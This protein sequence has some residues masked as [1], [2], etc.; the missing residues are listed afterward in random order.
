MGWTF[1]S[2]LRPRG[3]T[4][5][6]GLGRFG[7]GHGHGPVV[8][9]AVAVASIAA[10][11]CVDAGTKHAVPEPVFYAK[12]VKGYAETAGGLP[13][14]TVLAWDLS[15]VGDLARWRECASA[16]TCTMVERTRPAKDLVGVE[17]LGETTVEGRKAEVVKLSLAA[18][19]A[20]I[21]PNFKPTR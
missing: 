12:N 16:D 2:G 17:R 3:V 19:P 5:R 9:V 1:R 7:F 20:Y 14:D 15:I 8:A 10:T 18:R 6:F 21:V 4:A 13:P 11:G